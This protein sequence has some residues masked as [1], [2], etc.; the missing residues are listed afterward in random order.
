MAG[1]APALHHLRMVAT[2]ADMPRFLGNTMLEWG[3]AGVIAAVLLLLTLDNLGI[4]IT[5]L[6]A[7][8]GIGGV[9]IALAV[10]NILGDLFASLSITFDKPFVLGDFLVVDN[11][12]GSVEAIGIK[13]TRLRSLT[14]EQIVLSNADLLGS[15]VR[16]YQSLKERRVEFGFSVAPTTP[17]QK[18]GELP[19]RVRAVIEQQREVRFDRCHFA[20]IGAS[21]LD[22]VAVYFV[23][24]PDFNIYMDIQQAINLG[25]LQA[26]EEAKVELAFPR[27]QLVVPDAVKI[28]AAADAAAN[29]DIR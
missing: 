21:S 29:A 18:A 3:T 25:I 23:R 26:L 13:T 12:M 10:Q 9:A 8:L 19:A 2:P 6:V 5:T 1:A 24:N 14:G 28:N 7:G 16:N 17:R 22:Y 15:R 27:Q 11:Y 20:A 4:N